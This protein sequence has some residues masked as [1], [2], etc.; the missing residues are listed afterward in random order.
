[1]VVDG[2]IKTAFLLEF[3]K[4]EYRSRKNL[5]F[6]KSLF[7]QFKI[8]VVIFSKRFRF[9]LQCLLCFDLLNKVLMSYHLQFQA[10]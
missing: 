1:M 10:F 5:C 8:F 2:V 6:V 7:L 9:S 4:P 3:R